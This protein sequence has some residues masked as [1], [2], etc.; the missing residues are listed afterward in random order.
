MRVMREV[1]RGKRDSII[2]GNYKIC[3]T[4]M[5]ASFMAIVSCIIA[6][7]WRKLWI[8]CLN[9]LLIFLYLLRHRKEERKVEYIQ[10]IQYT[11][12][13]SV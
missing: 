1:R 9:T 10:G 4:G 12:D 2:G 5:M 3:R 7:S 6:L 13:S 8:A 11:S